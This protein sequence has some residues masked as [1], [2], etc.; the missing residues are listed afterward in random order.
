MIWGQMSFRK[1]AYRGEGPFLILRMKATI[2]MVATDAC[3]DLLAKVVLA[4]FSILKIPTLL[5]SE[6]LR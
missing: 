5:I 4:G 6:L 3:L 1:E 2:S